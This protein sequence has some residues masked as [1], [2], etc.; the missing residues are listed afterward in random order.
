[1]STGLSLE[2]PDAFVQ[3]CRR[4]GPA[5]HAY[6]ARRTG[7]QGADDLFGE[8]WLRAYAGRAAY[9]GRLG[10]PLPWLYGI[11][12]ECPTCALA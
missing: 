2:D 9:D 3:L 10:D 1:M 4:R 12:L 11:A 6:L 7:R 5:I 8:V